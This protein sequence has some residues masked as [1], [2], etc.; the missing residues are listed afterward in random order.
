MA[1]HGEGG[2]HGEGGMMMAHH[3]GGDGERMMGGMGHGGGHMGPGGGGPM[4][5]HH[6]GGEEMM[7]EL[8]MLGVHF[9]PPPMLIRRAKE[10]G[11]TPDQVNK[12]RQE[13]LTTHSKSIDLHAKVEH[14]KVEVAR[15]LSAD[16]VDEKAVDAQIDEGAKA[17]SEL[18]KLHLGTM[19]RVRAMLTPEQRQKLDEKK[20]RKHPGAKPGAGAP[21]GPVGQADDDDDDDDDDME[22]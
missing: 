6:P 7:R 2:E 8:G 12:L 19:L 16:K 1:H 20:S 9:Y 11:L 15:L 10:L 21:P 22:G 5:G 3:P 13:M 14:S 4:M 18:H 17:E